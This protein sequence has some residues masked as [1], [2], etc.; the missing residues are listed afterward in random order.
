MRCNLDITKRR[1][2]LIQS[3]GEWEGESAGIEHLIC[4]LGP[5]ATLPAAI[6]P[7]AR[8]PDLEGRHGHD[9]EQGQ[10]LVVDLGGRRLSVNR[11]D[12]DARTMFECLHLARRHVEAHAKDRPRVVGVLVVGLDDAISR[13]LV[14]AVIL[15]LLAETASM[16]AML[17]KPRPRPRLERIEVTGIGTPLDRDRLLA[18]DAGNA[19]ARYL[20]GLPSNHLRPA[21]YRTHLMWISGEEGWGMDFLDR[22]R[23]EGLGAGAF[24]AVCRGSQDDDAG[25]VRLSYRP[26]GQELEDPAR[27]A[28]VGKGICFDTGGVNLKQARH[29]HGMHEDMQGSAVALGTLLALSRLG[30][31]YGIDCWLALAVNDIGPGAFRQ[32]EVVEA[33]DG[34]TIEIVHTDAEGRMVL[35]D[36]LALASRGSPAL[37]LDYATLTGTCVYALGTR[38]S[39]ACTNRDTLREALIEAGRTSGERV[40]P[41]PLDEDFDEAI[42]SRIADCRQCALEGE[43]DQIIAARFLQ[44]FVAGRPWVHLDLSAGNHKGGLAHIPTD[45]SGFGVLF[46]LALL[47]DHGA[48]DIVAETPA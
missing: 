30:V 22:A 27:L 33:C 3:D 31:P 2:E 21:D 42:E 17:S 16:P 38:Y 39:G 4:L 5:E 36:T 45:I 28:L 24:L 23:L 26:A 25:I 47:L 34:T 1:I 8:L 15:A 46:S 13:P 41:F 40:W 48:L 29:M 43:A 44:R 10:P 19:L 6:D 9:D 37:I 11:I 12:G 32:N 18:A 20:T 7:D 35:A 14:E